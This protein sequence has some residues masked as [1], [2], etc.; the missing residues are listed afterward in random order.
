[1]PGFISENLKSI[2]PSLKLLTLRFYGLYISNRCWNGFC[3]SVKI[4]FFH[5]ELTRY[6]QT[7]GFRLREVSMS[8]SIVQIRNL[9]KIYV[10]DFIGTEFGRL[11]I[12]LTFAPPGESCLSPIHLP[13]RP[14][15]KFS[16]LSSSPYN[17]IQSTL[18][19]G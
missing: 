11:K 4:P 3:Q 9:S 16:L 5:R 2:I 6:I 7:P 10:R 13:C 18:Y 17:L 15:C 19:S 14:E 12:R 1:M 8:E